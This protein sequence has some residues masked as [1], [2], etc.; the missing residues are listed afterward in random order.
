MACMELVEELNQTLQ[1]YLR[2]A[3]YPVAIKILDDEVQFRAKT[4]RPVRD[5]G[6][7]LN[8]CQGIAMVRRYG[9]TIGF[10][11]EDH[12]CANSL[13]ILGLLKEPE[14][15]RDGSI[16][17]GPY[18]DSLEHGAI[19]QAV[20]PRSDKPLS[21]ILA[22]PLHKAEFDPDVVLV[23]CNPGQAVRL[24]QSALYTT[25]GVLESRF[26]G[27]CACG[28]EIVSTLQTGECQIVIPGGGEKV[29]A[30][31]ADDEMV[32]TI[33]ARRMRGVIDGLVG[34]HKAGANRYPAPYFGLRAEP[35]FPAVYERLERYAGL[36][37]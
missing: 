6:H 1:T 2:A 21:A 12:A 10:C 19:T 7:R 16:V 3:T 30:M 37:T 8:I 28:T 34:T 15:I 22:M 9:W 36:R 11:K 24:I 25:G 17:A 4:K 5:L 14:F 23:Y 27:R 29:F 32:F 33:P 26:M 20:T 13:V 35:E 31:L 18:T